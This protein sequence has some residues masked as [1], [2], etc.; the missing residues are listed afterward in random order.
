MGTSKSDLVFI[1]AASFSLGDQIVVLQLRR[2]SFVK[3]WAHIPTDHRVKSLWMA[4][5]Q[6]TVLYA[7]CAVSTKCGDMLRCEVR[8]T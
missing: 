3:R 1:L 8:S 2:R 7:C 6:V 4:T 5:Y